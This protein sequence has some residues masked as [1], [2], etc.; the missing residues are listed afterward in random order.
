MKIKNFY[1]KLLQHVLYYYL[2][3]NGSKNKIKQMIGDSTN[4]NRNLTVNQVIRFF[5]RRNAS[6]KQRLWGKVIKSIFEDLKP[7]LYSARKD[8]NNRSDALDVKEFLI[9]VPK[10]IELRNKVS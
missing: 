9:L 3:K 2:P 6:V 7:Y 8:F 1:G 10:A 4:N 5:T